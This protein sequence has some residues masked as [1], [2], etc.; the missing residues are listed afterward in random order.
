MVTTSAWSV[1]A[2]YSRRLSMRLKA[3]LWVSGWRLRMSELEMK[4]SVDTKELQSMLDDFIKNTLPNAVREI[5][6]DEMHKQVK[7]AAMSRAQ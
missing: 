6:R 7:A 5:V 1:A 2:R 4:I 3:A